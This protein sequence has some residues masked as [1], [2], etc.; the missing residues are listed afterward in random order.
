MTI[1]ELE[2][3]TGSFGIVDYCKI[4]LIALWKYVTVVHSVQRAVYF[5]DCKI[6][7]YLSHSCVALGLCS[8]Q[9]WVSS[10]C[11]RV[12]GAVSLPMSGYSVYN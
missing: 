5:V 8:A 10:F 9:I 11:D 2:I 3:Q 1:L 4:D 12:Q 7:I 6:A